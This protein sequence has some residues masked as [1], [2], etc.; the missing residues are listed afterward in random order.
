MTNSTTSYKSVVQTV[1]SI[2]QAEGVGARVRRSIGTTKLRNLDPFLMLDEFTVYKPAG[3]PDHP[4]RGFETVTYMM[5]GTFNH[6][7]FAGHKGTIGPGDLQWMTAGRGIIHAEMPGEQPDGE[8]AHGL[9]L[10][11]NLPRK[12]KL[13]KPRYQ[14]LL[15]KQV[16]RVTAPT[17]DK[18]QVKVIAGDSYNTKAAVMTY[19]PILYLDVKLGAESTTSDVFEQLVPEGWTAFVYTLAGCDIVIHTGDKTTTVGPHTT[20][21]LSEEG[22]HLKVTAGSDKEAH[23]VLIAGQKLKEPIVQ[24]GPFVMSTRDEIMQAFMDYEMGKN[25]FEG[26]KKWASKIGGRGLGKYEDYDGEP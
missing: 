7:D 20:A 6:E 3:F 17:S 8:P 24:H 11:V 26:A 22:S 12:D 23:F 5:Q 2:E 4:H 15:D 14:E 21:V 19:T 9:Q 25:G 16:P 1:L 18:V 10:W 13:V